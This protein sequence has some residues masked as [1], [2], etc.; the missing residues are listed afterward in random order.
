MTIQIT[1][2]DIEALINRRLETGLFKDAEDVILQAL[3]SSETQSR[4]SGEQRREAIDRLMGFGIKTGTRG[5]ASETSGHK[6][7][8]EPVKGSAR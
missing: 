2:A 6:V 3:T 7:E 5:T 4:V 1:R 8:P